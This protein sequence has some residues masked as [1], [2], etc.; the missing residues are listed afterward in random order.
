MQKITIDHLDFAQQTLFNLTT[1]SI[2]HFFTPIQKTMLFSL[3]N[4]LSACIM[5]TAVLAMEPEHGQTQKALRGFLEAKT[6]VSSVSMMVP[7]VLAN[8]RCSH[9]LFRSPFVGCKYDGSMRF[10]KPPLFTLVVPVFFCS[11]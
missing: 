11:V 7:C 2:Y 3:T 4:A 6:N 9:W 1:L 10:G 5:T 8:H